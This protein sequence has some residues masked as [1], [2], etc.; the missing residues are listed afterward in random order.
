MATATN[1]PWGV[2]K[3]APL[4]KSASIAPASPTK[5]GDPWGV[6]PSAAKGSDPWAVGSAP[7]TTPQPKTASLGDVFNDR[8]FP[9]IKPIEAAAKNAGNFLERKVIKPVAGALAYGHAHPNDVIMGPL[10]AGQRALR[11][12]E[13]NDFGGQQNDIGHDFMTPKVGPQLQAGVQKMLGLQPGGFV[14]QHMKPGVSNALRI[15]EDVGN[16][17][18]NFVGGEAL[19]MI[20]GGKAVA[21]AIGKVA[22]KIPKVPILNP[23]DYLKG[24]KPEA[25]AEFEMVTNQSMQAVR[26]QKEA[27]D[28]IVAAHAAE[29]RAGKM[30]DEV[31]RLFTADKSTPQMQAWQ[32]YFPKGFRKG[33]TPQEVQSALFRNRAPVFKTQVMDALKKRGFFNTPE[34]IAAGRNLNL[35]DKFDIPSEGLGNKGGWS[36]E[37]GASNYQHLADT[38]KRLQQVVERPFAA[39][40]PV[41]K[42][43]QTLMHRGNQA[44]LANPVPHTFNLANLSYLKYGAPTT[45]AGLGNAARVATGT[46]GKGKLAQDIGELGDLGARS[47]YSNIFDELGLTGL[48]NAPE[49]GR[50]APLARAF[51]ATVA[52]ATRKAAQAVNKPLIL[53]QRAS[54]AMQHG[55]LNSTETGLRAAALNAEKRGGKTGAQAAQAIH[56]AF[57]TDAPNTLSQAGRA[58]AAPFIK[59]HAQTAPGA[60][61]GALAR[62]P[63]RISNPIKIESDLNAKS[64]PQYHSTTPGL[65]AGRM[66]G[67]PVNYFTSNMGVGSLLNPYGPLAALKSGDAKKISQALTESGSRYVTGSP[68]LTALAEMASKKKGQAG[69]SGLQDFISALVGGYFAKH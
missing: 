4:A 39:P 35:D 28:K 15:G 16:D 27:E 1:D 19:K 7:A 26:K 54:N 58:A 25:R 29:I 40:N 68:E 24:L 17:P 56:A 47:Q 22:D 43:A 44:F 30:P 55:V 46:V 51:N 57:G 3:P 34:S 67:D 33:T 31:A 10:Q 42:V 63:S 48:K 23:Q 38:Q 21:G 65:N 64:G 45:L 66:I 62:N 37:T 69:E 5:G 50:T 41:Q 53:G 9:V 6:Q 49:T 2:A 13:L 52:P 59:F 12:A 32:Q 14:D 8:T 20:P 11:G 60:V 61:L 36:P 18:L